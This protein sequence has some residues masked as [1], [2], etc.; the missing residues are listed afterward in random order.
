[1][2]PVDT[3]RMTDQADSIYLAGGGNSSQ[4]QHG[5]VQL[6]FYPTLDPAGIATGDASLTVKNVSNTGNA[7]LLSLESDGPLVRDGRL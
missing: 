7:L 6:A 2:H 5:D 1:M 3:P 4:F